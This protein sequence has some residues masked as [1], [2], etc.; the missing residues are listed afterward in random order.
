MAE[1]MKAAFIG[2][3]VMGYPMVGHLRNAG[4]TVAVY[5]R[6]TAKAEAWAAEEA[7]TFHA[8]PREAASGCDVVFVIIEFS[9]GLAERHT[10]GR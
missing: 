8:T 2:L 1:H 9:E 3:G 6:M 10:M 4:H 7:G 5:N